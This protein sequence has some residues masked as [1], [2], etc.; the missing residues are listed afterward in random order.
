[1]KTF[2]DL[3]RRLVVGVTVT[4]T[5]HDWFPNGKLLGVPRKIAIQQTNAVAFESIEDPKK[6]PSWLYFKKA[7]EFRI[8]GPDSFSVRLD[9]DSSKD[10][11]MSYTIGT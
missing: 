10:E 7:S 8:D 11:W 6:Q 1:M 9:P 5:R 2:A 3:K 4:M